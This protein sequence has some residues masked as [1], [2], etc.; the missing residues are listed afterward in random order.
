M[1]LKRMYIVY[2]SVV[3][4]TGTKFD[5]SKIVLEAVNAEDASEH[6]Q[7]LAMKFTNLADPDRVSVRYIV[8]HENGGGQ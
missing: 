8:E 7:F 3:D 5:D 2:V 1:E 6:A 4:K